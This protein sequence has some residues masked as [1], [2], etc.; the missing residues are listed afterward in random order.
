MA[1]HVSPCLVLAIATSLI[2]RKTRRSAS[3]RNVRTSENNENAVQAKTHLPTSTRVG[4]LKALP[5]NVLKQGAKRTALSD[6]SNRAPI[7][8]EVKGKPAID[9]ARKS[10]LA[11]P[12]RQEISSHAIPSI[13]E[14]EDT[15]SDI[16]MDEQNPDAE[17]EVEDLGVATPAVLSH[18]I[19]HGAAVV[20]P[21]YL[22]S[23]QLELRRVATE[24]VDEW[25]EWK[26]ISMIQEYADDIFT[27]LHELEVSSPQQFESQSLPY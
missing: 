11:R 1:T 18:R 15:E 4:A 5:A 23:D 12:L 20:E 22:K 27:Y 2:E 3:L 26:D 17:M 14:S 8:V 13:P 24:F 25:D 6:V 10:Q 21:V 19:A 9:H 7:S 16:S